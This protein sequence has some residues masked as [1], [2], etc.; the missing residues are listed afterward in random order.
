MSNKFI[1]IVRWRIGRYG[2]LRGYNGLFKEFSG[3][4]DKISEE[5]NQSSIGVEIMI[6]DFIRNDSR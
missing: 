3:L 2:K 5:S 1:E 6:L 4:K